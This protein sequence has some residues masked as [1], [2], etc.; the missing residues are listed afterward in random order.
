M[1]IEDVTG[2]FLVPGNCGEDCPGKGCNSEIA[3]C[4]EECDY[5]ICCLKIHDSAECFTCDDRDCPRATG[6]V[7]T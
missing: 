5:L 1:L 4:C 7:R 6:G 3:C 2:V